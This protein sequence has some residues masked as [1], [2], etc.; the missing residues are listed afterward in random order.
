MSGRN[1]SSSKNILTYRSIMRK[2]GY[3]LADYWTEGSWAA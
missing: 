3:T 2:Y 1:Y